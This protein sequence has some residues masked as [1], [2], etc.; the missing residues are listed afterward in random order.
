M[1]QIDQEPINGIKDKVV[2]LLL[3][4]VVEKRSIYKHNMRIFKLELPN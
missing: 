2:N 1:R 4:T 3:Q